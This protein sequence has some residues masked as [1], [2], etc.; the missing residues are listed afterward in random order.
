[1]EHYHYTKEHEWV[2]LEDTV[3][4]VGITEYAQSSMGEVTF[5]ELPAV[6]AEV[7]QFEQFA[8][9]ESVKAAS[10]IYCPMSGKVVEV[11]SELEEDPELLNKD[12]YEAGWIAKIEISNPEELSK[13]MSAE[14][15]ENYLESIG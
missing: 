7:E 1:M 8:S 4:T 9:V 5:V 12:C 2:Y 11:N 15:Y 14:E 3:A 10:D 6:N 13:L